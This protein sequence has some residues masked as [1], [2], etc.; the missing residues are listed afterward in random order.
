MAGFEARE[1]RLWGWQA[2]QMPV[3]AMKSLHRLSDDNTESRTHPNPAQRF[4]SVLR[5]KEWPAEKS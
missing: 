5:H 1:V 3:A 4:A 2:D